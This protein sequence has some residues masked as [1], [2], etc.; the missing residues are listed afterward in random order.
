[1]ITHKISTIGQLSCN[2][3]IGG[4]G[5]GHLVREVDAMGGLMASVA[6]NSGTMFHVLNA[7]KGA[8]VQG[9]RAQVD[10]ALYLQHMQRQLC[11]VSRLSVCQA[12]VEDLVVDSG[13]ARGVVLAD[14]IR[15]LASCTVL[16]T[17]TFLRGM[18]HMGRSV[19][20]LIACKPEISIAAHE[21]QPPS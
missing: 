17:G 15:V 19:L 3:S 14:G 5:K 6:D 4:V 7:S 2:P 10:R 18:I 16:T 20:R 13:R 11:A 12:S 21:L 1:M 8:A 9:P